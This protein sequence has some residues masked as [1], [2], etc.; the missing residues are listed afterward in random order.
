MEPYLAQYG[1]IVDKETLLTE[2]REEIGDRNTYLERRFAKEYPVEK[3]K[4]DRLK[5]DA[6]AAAEC[7]GMIIPLVASLVPFVYGIYLFFQYGKNSPG[8]TNADAYCLIWAV[9]MGVV[10]WLKGKG[11]RFF[12][13]L[14]LPGAAAFVAAAIVDMWYAEDMSPVPLLPWFCMALPVLLLLSCVKEARLGLKTKQR[15]KERDEYRQQ[16]ILPIQAKLA[17]E[18]RKK[19]ITQVGEENLIE[20]GS[21]N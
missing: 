3:E 19:W 18:V 8:Y 9:M 11:Q 16:T 7:D 4:W 13:G 12:V 6:A 21:I 15:E 1:A 5:E 14:I 10:I 17:V 20:L 2:Y